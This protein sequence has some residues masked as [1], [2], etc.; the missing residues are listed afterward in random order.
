MARA[1]TDPEWGRP[2][3]GIEL[4]WDY[5]PRMRRNLLATGAVAMALSGTLG[6]AWA[7]GDPSTDLGAGRPGIS[8]FDLEVTVRGFEPPADGTE[9]P[10]VL[11]LRRADVLEPGCGSPTT[12]RIELDL[13]PCPENV[14]FFVESP[15][16]D[17]PIVMELL[18]VRRALRFDLPADVHRFTITFV[19]MSGATTAP[20]PI[21]L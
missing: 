15:Q 1:P 6:P 11:D 18:G 7:E 21:E 20:L 8:L 10:R 9:P 4:G 12:Q 17:E 19:E 3:S 2:H 5:T 13:D 14:W 16:L